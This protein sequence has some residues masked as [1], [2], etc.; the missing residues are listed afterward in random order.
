MSATLLESKS[1]TAFLRHRGPVSCVVGIPGSHKVLSASYDGAVGLFDLETRS[2]EL[3]GYHHHLVNRITVSP[4]A[5]RAAS[6]S[7]DYTVYIWDLATRRVERVL[8]G[9]IDDVDDFRSTDR[10]HWGIR[11]ARLPNSDLGFA[12]RVHHE[13][14]R[15]PR[16]GRHLRGIPGWQVVHLRRRQDAP[17]LGRRLGKVRDHVGAI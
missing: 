4:S 7:S 17:R 1:D 5:K 12:H 8:R 11:I 9:H 16:K 6:S 2:V 3:L 13:D 10:R 15:R 14:S